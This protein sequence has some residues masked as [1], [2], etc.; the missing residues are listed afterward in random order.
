MAFM[1]DVYGKDYAANT[2]ETI[3]RQTI[4][5]FEQA[6]IVNCNSD[7]PS[8]PTNSGKTV[9]RLTDEAVEVLRAFGTAVFDD[10]VLEFIRK[11]GSLQAAYLRERT[12][13]SVP[14][15][16]PDGTTVHLSPGEHNRVQVAVIEEFGP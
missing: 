1:R 7:D 10:V 2:R 13:R 11:F 9:Y 4:H 8:R 14:L 16:L 12:T 3:R 5:R 15:K 6:R